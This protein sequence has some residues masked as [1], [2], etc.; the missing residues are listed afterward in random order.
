MGCFNTL[1][2]DCPSCGVQTE[3]Q[4]K[5]GDMD[6]FKYSV[7]PEKFLREF[8]RCYSCDANFTV[9][10]KEQPTFEIVLVKDEE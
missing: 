3:Q 10:Y 8:F 1:L 9:D 6:T 7:D 4:T 2:I 5:P